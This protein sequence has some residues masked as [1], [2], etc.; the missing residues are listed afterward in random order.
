MVAIGFWS[1]V[2]VNKRENRRW[3]D[4]RAF[5]TNDE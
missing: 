5:Q 1:V 4:P 2:F 3:S